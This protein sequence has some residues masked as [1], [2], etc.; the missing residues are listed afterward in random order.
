[1]RESIFSSLGEHVVGARVA[2][3]FAGSGS[4]GLEAL[5]R[6]A[7]SAVFVERDAGALKALRQNVATVD[8]GGTVLR[9]DVVDAIGRIDGP[10]D[11]AFVDPPYAMDEA[12][13]DAVLRRLEP[14]VA[15]GGLVLV[16][17]RRDHEQRE[18]AGTLR[19]TDVRRYGDAVVR[20][21]RKEAD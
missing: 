4:F 5:S 19:V 21:H 7:A 15:P 1:M 11:L 9:G 6:G 12:A 13:V 18:G 10:L 3:L 20:W 8:L 17:R 2:D 14:L 16:H